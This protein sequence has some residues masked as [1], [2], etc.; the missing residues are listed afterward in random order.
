MLA[1]GM[2]NKLRW[3]LMLAAAVAS[4]TRPC[5]T[6]ELTSCVGLGA[7]AS[8]QLA[9]AAPERVEPEDLYRAGRL[10]LFP[11]RRDLAQERRKGPWDFSDAATNRFTYFSPEAVEP[12]VTDKVLRFRTGGGKVVLGW[13]NF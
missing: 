13:G 2:C 9:A 8:T 5:H 12:Q 6:Q 11:L 7:W 10:K 3:A 1:K 4:G